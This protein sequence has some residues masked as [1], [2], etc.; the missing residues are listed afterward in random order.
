[1]MAPLEVELTILMPCLNEAR[2]LE[3]CIRKAQRFLHEAGVQG[4]VVVA[5][6][7]STDGSPEIA[8]CAGA[9]VVEVPL[10][11]Y[12][13]ALGEGSRQAHGRFIIM[14]DADDSYDFLNLMPFVEG[15]RAGNDLVMGNRF[16]HGIQTGAM[17]WKNRWIGNPGVTAIGRL[18]FGAR[19][20]DFYCGLRG[21]SRAAFDRMDLRTTGMEFALEMVMK[22]TFLKMRVIEVRTTLQPDGR[23]RP[24]HLRPWRD[25]WRSLRFMLLYSPRWLFL[26]PGLAVLLA[27]LGFFIRLLFGSIRLGPVRLDVDTLRYASAMI[28]I[29]FQ[30]VLFWVYAQAFAVTEGL[31]WA[32]DTW[33]SR[34][35]RH[36]TL[37]T[38]LVAGG[39]LVLLGV[40]G[41]LA[42]LVLWGRHSF[43]NMNT[44]TLLRLVDPSALAMIL[45]V[46]IILSSFFLSMLLL[47]KR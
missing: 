3:T 11:G 10:R 37:E 46:Q 24:P 2:T 18:F 17:P 42:G 14:G 43:G 5:D 22:A 6:N 25:G 33:L 31:R 12:G 32:E 13:A 1:M 40:A 44:D 19:V 21:F 35:G 7:G 16:L 4:E 26:Y 41:G 47:K 29:G 27:G 38:G 9:R 39:G 34:I 8:R 28:L 23:D 36:L 45:G 30:S 15:L 20:G